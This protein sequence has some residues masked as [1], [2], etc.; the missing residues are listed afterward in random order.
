MTPIFP[1]YFFLLGKNK[2][3][4]Q[5]ICGGGGGFHSILWSH[6]LSIGLKLGC[7]NTWILN[8]V[9]YWLQ[10][11][12]IATLKHVQLAREVLIYNRIDSEGPPTPHD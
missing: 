7:D 2:V 12:I 4:Y 10:I 5:I 9:L 11:H 1:L 8:H 6:Q 3:A